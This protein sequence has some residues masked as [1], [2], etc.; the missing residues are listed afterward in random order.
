[1]KWHYLM[2]LLASLALIA[3]TFAEEIDIP[4]DID[5][6]ELGEYIGYFFCCNFNCFSN[7]DE[8]EEILRMLEQKRI[9]RFK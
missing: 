6:D 5:E 7:L 1:M 8:D 4:E 9:V 2:I 3:G